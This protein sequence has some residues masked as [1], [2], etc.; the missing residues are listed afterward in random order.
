MNI[1]LL[2][3][4]FEAVAIV[5][6]FESFIWTDRFNEAGDF[7]FYSKASLENFNLFKQGY[8]LKMDDSNKL[9][10]IEG[11]EI[12]SDIDDGNKI[13][14][15]GR[16]LES[17]L[18]RR[19]IWE[20][21]NVTG[22]IQSVIKK[23][24][25]DSILS[26]KIAERKINNF[27]F[28]ESDDER[29]TSI[30]IEDSQFTGENVYD[31]VCALCQ[32]YKVG[33]EITLDVNKNFVFRLYLGTDRT[34][35]QTDVIAVIF[36]KSFDNIIDSSYVSDYVTYKNITLV[37]GEGEGTSRKTAVVGDKVSSGIDRRELFTDA[38]DI[39][40]T[41]DSG[42][43]S[44]SKYTKLL[45]K[46]GELK[47]DE[48]NITIEFNGQVDADGLFRYGVDFFLGDLVHFYDEY[49]NGSKVRVDEMI[50]S[51]DSNGKNAY[52]S[53]VVLNDNKET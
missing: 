30:N 18:D 13:R 34:N 42:T 8:Y 2:D 51:W 33:F 21:T 48:N 12:I 49:N 38:R 43:I 36:S 5:D 29:I 26:P 15:V 9:M 4:N 1:V 19:I 16:S 39:S 52:P 28:E 20:Q 31:V 27:I 3:L 11:I 14:V 32:Q 23:L 35:D 6:M 53:F 41:T 47:L 37:A 40:S 22:D 46:R 24:L 17:L 50:F 44:A 25:T 7:E 45:E 10:I